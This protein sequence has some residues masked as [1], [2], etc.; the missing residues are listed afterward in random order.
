MIKE[1]PPAPAP[2][3]SPV[4]QDI[5]S[6]PQSTDYEGRT[7]WDVAT[8]IG[9]SIKNAKRVILLAV[10][11]VGLVWFFG[12]VAILYL[13]LSLVVGLAMFSWLLSPNGVIVDVVKPC[14]TWDTHIVGRDLWNEIK[15]DGPPQIKQTSPVHTG[16][17]RPRF[18]AEDFDLDAKT[19]K[20]SWVSGL[21]LVDYHCDASA[22]Q[23]LLDFVSVRMDSWLDTLAFP[24]VMG[25]AY[26]GDIIEAFLGDFGKRIKTLDPKY[27][28]QS[29]FNDRVKSTEA[30][31]SSE[32][33]AEAQGVVQR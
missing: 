25:Q 11:V 24:T 27:S 16:L 7:G 20:F 23:R 31:S 9:R 4:N 8:S 32:D 12:M 29:S 1:A 5:A 18:V 15:H 26:A 2:A 28:Q 21:T 13:V 14:G 19:V 17:G 30:K 10:V 33:P 3:P 6:R 22:Y